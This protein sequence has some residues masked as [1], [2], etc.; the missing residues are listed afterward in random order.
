MPRFAPL[1]LMILLAGC[2]ADKV[3]DTPLKDLALEAARRGAL[4]RT[5][6]S[7]TQPD[8][9]DQR[10]RTD[11][12]MAS[13]LGLRIDYLELERQV[14]E[15]NANAVVTDFGRSC[16]SAAAKARRQQKK[17]LN[18]MERRLSDVDHRRWQ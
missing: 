3:N 7:G 17:L 11:V 14:A 4:A 13:G 10:L 15:E 12:E 2:S 5:C 1:I 9:L 8:D 18:D 16:R 6:R